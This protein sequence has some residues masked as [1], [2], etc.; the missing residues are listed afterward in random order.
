MCNFK[1]QY[2]ASATPLCVLFRSLESRCDK[3][4]V[5]EQA[6]QIVLASSHHWGFLSS[7]RGVGCSAG[8]SVTNECVVRL[9]DLDCGYLTESL[10]VT[11]ENCWWIPG[12]IWKKILP[13][14][15]L[16]GYLKV[17]LLIFVSCGIWYLITLGKKNNTEK[18]L[19]WLKKLK[20]IP[21]CLAMYLF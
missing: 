15:G 12:F 2:T 19:A 20:V 6:T 5:P 10:L 17:V 11:E 1:W 3:P 9:T 13:L 21:I 7:E 16:R 14:I 4:V 8:T 18:F